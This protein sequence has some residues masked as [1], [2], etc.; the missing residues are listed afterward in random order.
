MRLQVILHKGPYDGVLMGV[1]RRGKD[2]PTE[3][4]IASGDDANDPLEVHEY[5][6]HDVDE[7]GTIFMGSY[8]WTH[9]FVSARSLVE[10]WLE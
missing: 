2:W 4:R 8:I 10:Y 9:S 6:R 7:E 5:R 1:N 3:I